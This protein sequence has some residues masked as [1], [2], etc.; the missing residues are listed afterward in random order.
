MYFLSF[1]FTPDV[2]KSNVNKVDV[3]SLL[4]CLNSIAMHR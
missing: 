1:L 4:L 2:F 3:F